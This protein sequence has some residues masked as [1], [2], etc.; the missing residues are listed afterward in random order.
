MRF[1]MD[2][3]LWPLAFVATFVIGW[4]SATIVRKA[5]GPSD[6]TQAQEVVRLQQQVTT[7]QARLRAREDLAAGRSGSDGYSASA[8]GGA[9]ERAASAGRGRGF[10]L[11][12]MTQPAPATKPG[13]SPTVASTADVKT[14]LDK[15]YKY[16]EAMN[17][18]EGRDRWRRSRELME[19]LKAM[20]PAAGQALMQVLAAGNDMEERR[21]AA[22]MLGQLQTPEAIPALRDI[23]DRESDVLLRRAAAQGL[24]Q[25]QTPDTV[26]VMDKLLANPNEDRFV[27]LSAAFGLAEAGQTSGVNGLASIFNE[28][29]GDGRGREAAFRAMA[30]L[31]DERPLPFMRQVAGS[32]AEPGYR[33]QA[34]RYVA[35]QGDQQSLPVLQRIMQSPTEQQSVR[36]AAA[37]AFSSLGG[38]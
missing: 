34:I 16:L 21:A 9:D 23:L 11:A 22:R 19:E 2:R 37:Q 14:A 32:Q 3:L 18:P 36:D 8:S 5:T 29:T 12:S 1:D 35:A 17:A 38:K 6:S 30:S 15:F 10:D 31:K 25:M 26:P 28:A 27:R 20:G 33:V 4:G 24:R 13:P 7:L